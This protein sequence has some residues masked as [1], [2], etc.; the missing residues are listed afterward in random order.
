M[1][2]LLY[3]ETSQP[4]IAGWLALMVLLEVLGFDTVDKSAQAQQLQAFSF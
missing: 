3:T 2:L 1:L 4:A